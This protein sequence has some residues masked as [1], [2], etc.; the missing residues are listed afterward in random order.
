MRTTRRHLGT[1]PKDIIRW[2]GARQVLDHG[3]Q[4]KARS[5]VALAMK[6]NKGTRT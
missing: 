5:A 3:R 4:R 2:Q 1:G 6:V